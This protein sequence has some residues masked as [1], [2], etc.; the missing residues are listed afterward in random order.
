ML[1]DLTVLDEQGIDLLFQC[2]RV[3]ISA[4]V[5]LQVFRPATRGEI[6]HRCANFEKEVNEDKRRC[7][8]M[9][10]SGIWIAVL[11]VTI[12]KQPL[13]CTKI[14]QQQRSRI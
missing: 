5:C 2:C 12:S 13:S 7:S 9:Y 6:D 4:Q 11:L 3:P 8:D 1:G 10:I 14:A